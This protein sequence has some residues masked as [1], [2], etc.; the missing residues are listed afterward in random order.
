MWDSSKL[1]FYDFNLTSNSRNSIFTA[2]TFYPVWNDIIPDEILA[3]QANAFGYFATVNMAMNKYN[4]TFPATFV[5]WTALQWYAIIFR[6]R[7]VADVFPQGC[8]EYLASSPVHHHQ[9][10]R[11]VAFQPHNKCSP[12]TWFW[13]IDI[14]PYPCWP[15][16][17]HR[18]SA[19]WTTI[20]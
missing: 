11:G 13:T 12:H 5:D 8:T 15:A 17:L 16:Q 20:L 14:R 4:G 10:S 2:A 1:A 3:S 9:R 19:S 6:D 7:V 18:G